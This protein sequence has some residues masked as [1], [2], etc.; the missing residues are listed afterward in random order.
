M[1]RASMGT[2]SFQSHVRLRDTQSRTAIGP[3]TYTEQPAAAG[4]SSP[5]VRPGWG[6]HSVCA[7]GTGRWRSAAGGGRDGQSAAPAASSA[8]PAPRAVLMDRDAAVGLSRPP[9]VAQLRR[10]VGRSQSEVGLDGA[11]GPAVRGQ[12]V[13]RLSAGL[14]RP[15]SACGR[16]LEVEELAIP[17]L[18][19]LGRRRTQTSASAAMFALR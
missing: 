13:L 8:E 2:C 6:S 9:P 19:T 18:V 16:R 17:L 11:R 7:D 15:A 5:A 3:R 4:A 14:R 12:C 1:L 10:S